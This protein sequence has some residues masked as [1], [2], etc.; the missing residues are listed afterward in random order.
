M[1]E[2]IAKIL[3]LAKP[4]ATQPAEKPTISMSA[5]ISR[6][7]GFLALGSVIFFW[8]VLIAAGNSY[9][10]HGGDPNSILF[11]IAGEGLLLLGL[12]LL[13]II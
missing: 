11:L 13:A 6:V 12:S 2:E 10:I 3:E 8:P 4:S 1:P 9:K 7:C 5:S